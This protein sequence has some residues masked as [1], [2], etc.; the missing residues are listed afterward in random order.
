MSYEVDT[1][2]AGGASGA[3]WHLYL[4]HGQ[5]EG[6]AR[7]P[8]GFRSDHQ[9]PGGGHQLGGALGS[10]FQKSSSFE[11]PVCSPY[12]RRGWDGSWKH[13]MSSPASWLKDP[14]STAAAW[15]HS[16]PSGDCGQILSVSIY[17]AKAKHWVS[18]PHQPTPSIFC[19][20]LLVDAISP[21]LS[22]TDDKSF[23][24]YL[25]NISRVPPFLDYCLLP[26]T[27][28]IASQWDQLWPLYLNHCSIL[29]PLSMFS[30]HFSLLHHQLIP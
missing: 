16:R 6:M 20:L 19:R 1:G 30:F 2:K 9:W 12:R 4:P 22:P 7:A 23:Q 11:L 21:P 5:M 29:T 8:C 14:W 28:N 27:Q 3:Q 24:F 13:M 25:Q 10:S 26:F 18:V 17:L 15:F